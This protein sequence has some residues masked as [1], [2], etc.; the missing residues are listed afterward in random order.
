MS[1]KQRIDDAPC[2]ANCFVIRSE[3]RDEIIFME[4]KEAHRAV[5]W[6]I[7]PRQRALEVYKA[8]LQWSNEI[9]MS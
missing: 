5:L 2:F 7:R 1:C 6:L 8:W 4:K 3:I 9:V